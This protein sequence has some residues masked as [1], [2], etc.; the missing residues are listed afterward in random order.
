MKRDA[1]KD[2]NL[3]LADS[4]PNSNVLLV[5]GARQVGKTFLIHSSLKDKENLVTINF[6]KSRTSK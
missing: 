3:F 5:Q 1:E 2:V 4:Q 6:E